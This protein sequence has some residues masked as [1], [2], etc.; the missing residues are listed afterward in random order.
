MRNYIIHYDNIAVDDSAY[1]ERIQE[2]TEFYVYPPSRFKLLRTHKLTQ[3]LKELANSVCNDT[4]WVFVNALGHGVDIPSLYQTMIGQCTESGSPLMAHILHRPNEYPYLDAQCFLIDLSAWTKIGQPSFEPSNE[5]VV[6]N[7]LLRSEENAHD[8][9][10][11]LWVGPDSTE[12]SIKLPTRPFGSKVVEQFAQAG[13]RILN[14]NNDIRQ[15]KWYLYPNQ[16]YQEVKQFFNTGKYGTDLV[17]DI[18]N[19]IVKERESLK[20]TAYILNSEPVGHHSRVRKPIDH[21]VILAGG[22]KSALLVN[23]Y[24]YNDNTQIT[25]VDISTAGQAFQRFIREQWDGDLNN[26]YDLVFNQ[27][28]GDYKLAWRSWNTWES[29]V[30]SFLSKARL[31]RDQFKHVW[32]NYKSIPC[33]YMPMD[34]LG[35]TTKLTELVSKEKNKNFYIWFSNAF[36]MQWTRF[37]LGKKYTQDKKELLLKSFKQSQNNIVIEHGGQYTVYNSLV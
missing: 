10:T 1:K 22:F 36:D 14:F 31:T 24:G 16:N 7:N 9:Y 11:P 23:K 33:T 26:Y 2:I 20:D 27:F 34:L 12:Q 19:R 28:Q 29:E 37:M 32:Q 5:T 30:E 4:Q 15:Y 13:Y 8:D 35:D 3:T 25:C 17:P 18:I 6:L 21:Y